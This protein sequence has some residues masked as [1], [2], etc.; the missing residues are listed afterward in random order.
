MH[1]HVRGTV[2]ESRAVRLLA[3]AEGR[4]DRL[5]LQAAGLFAAAAEEH[6]P[7]HRR[8]EVRC[9]WANGEALRL[10]GRT[11][12]ARSVLL[13]T[14]AMAA[15]LGLVPLGGRIRRSLRLVGERRSAPRGA[16]GPL[17]GRE[18]EVLG[19]VGGGL[20]NSQIAVR[21][22]IGRPTVA[23]LVANAAAKLGTTSRAQTAARAVELE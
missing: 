20:T 2:F 21:L 8:S 3:T 6:A 13:A 12:E 17:T 22:G 18:R 14:E 9:R 19:L 23:R 10:A 11:D 16:G 1:A 15:D 7:F 5:W 4:D